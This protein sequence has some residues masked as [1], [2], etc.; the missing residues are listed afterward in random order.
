MIDIYM[1]THAQE[2]LS[3]AQEIATKF[4]W[5]ANDTIMTNKWCDFMKPQLTKILDQLDAEGR[6]LEGR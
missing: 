6:K 2:F 1:Q 3:A 4:R 5:L